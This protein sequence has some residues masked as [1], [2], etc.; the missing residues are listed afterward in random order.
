MIIDYVVPMVFEDDTEWQADYT[1]YF[2]CRNYTTGNKVRFRSWGTEYLLVRCIRRFMPFV[3]TIYIILAKESQRKDWMD[4]DGIKVV[5]H[6]EIIPRRF[7]PTYNSCT[8]E[9]FIPYIDG[10]AEC[11]IY[12]NDD[13]FPISPMKESDFFKDGLPVQHLEVRE[14]PE[15][16][17]IFHMKCMKQQ[18]MISAAF[19]KDLGS[20]GLHNGH[21]LA[22]LLRSSCLEVRK[23]FCKEISDGIKPERCTTSY[24]QYIYVLWQYFTGRYVDGR[25]KST[26]LSVKNTT[27]QIARVMKKTEGVVCVNDNECVGDISGYAA[28]VRNV[29][30]EKLMQE[31]KN[32]KNSYR[33]WVTYHKDELVGQYGL[34]EDDR[35][36]L[37]ATHR[38]PEKKNINW[39]NPVYSEMVTMWYVWKN[40]LKSDY[41]GFEH[42]RRHLDVRKMPRKGE[43]LVFR[44]IDFGARTVYEQYAQCHNAKDMDMVLSIL[45]KEYGEDN[46]YR[47]HIM[48]SRVLVAN[49]CFLMKWSDFKAMC[50]YLFPLLEEYGK[51]AVAEP[52]RLSDWREKAAKDFG[53]DRTDYQMRV[54]SFLA[55]RLI[56][57]WIT[58][59]MKW[60]N[61]IQVAV[62]HYNTPE[63]TDAAIRSLNKRTPG[64]MVTVFDNSDE[65][66]FVNNFGNVTVIDNTKG[67]VIDFDEMLS[68]YPDKQDDDRNRSNFGSAKHC[69][70]VDYLFDVLPDG[71]VLMDSD[72]LISKDIKG[73]V[74]H[75]KAV[76]G[77]RLTKDGVTLFQPMLCWLNVPMLK[78]NGIRYFNGEKMW[79]LSNT[80][81]N[82]RYDTGAWLYED[83]S[84][85]G[86]DFID[87]D[88][89]RY[90]IHFGHGS[91]RKKDYTQWLDNNRTLFE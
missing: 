39:L 59:H 80:F 28:L 32:E 56:S 71:F 31:R 9:M 45:D 68:H 81:P 23:R 60:N 41:V 82:N 52:E 73:F 69:R 15:E 44:A 53:N 26:Y 75:D 24:N 10:L 35:H 79:A 34:K 67:Q 38:E 64:C 36:V 6:S 22:P 29:L 63:L 43:C 49:C 1:S 55:E 77:T 40:N 7:L 16:R 3:R 61:G 11:F 12:G 27:E 65:K 17:N 88:I 25:V 87:I 8:I 19:D 4:E 54:V 84:G 2:K 33:I 13:M 14:F 42:Y 62:V 91:W 66:P 30:N 37:F 89:Y 47:K 85:K 48:E 5:Y 51:A 46:P 76:A 78:A 90:I 86:L 58:T 20:S 50:E 72:V 70:S 18:R 74:R 21:G 57:A 83:V